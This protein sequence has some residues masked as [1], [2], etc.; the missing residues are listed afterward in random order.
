MAHNE[1]EADGLLYYDYCLG[2]LKGYNLE[3]DTIEKTEENVWECVD[4]Q[5]AYGQTEYQIK[6]F[7]VY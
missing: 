2:R 4:R 6:E 5:T 7:G 1:Y 3:T